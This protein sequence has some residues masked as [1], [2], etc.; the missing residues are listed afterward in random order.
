MA[1]TTELVCRNCKK[2]GSAEGALWCSF[3]G[4][5]LY[6]P[7]DGAVAASVAIAASDMPYGDGSQHLAALDAD[8]DHEHPALATLAKHFA[9]LAHGI[10]DGLPPS[11]ER[12]RGVRKLLQART[13]ALTAAAAAIPAEPPGDVVVSRARAGIAVAPGGRGRPRGPVVVD[14]TETHGGGETT[15]E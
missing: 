8:D 9:E 4:A 14:D 15:P 1:T 12:E 10:V 2:E 7:P 6:P 11:A 13:S 5:K 3:C